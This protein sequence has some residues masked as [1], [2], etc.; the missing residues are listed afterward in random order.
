MMKQQGE[1]LAHWQ[2]STKMWDEF[3]TIEK[4]NKKEDNIY[5]GIGILIIAS[6]GLMFFRNTSFWGGLVFAIPFAIVIPWLRMKF[7]YTYLKKGSKNPEVKIFYDTLWINQKKIELRGDRK[8]I[9]SLKVI[10]AKNDLKLLEFDVQWM[11]A[12]GP[13]NDEFRILIP[14]SELEEV[15]NLIQKLS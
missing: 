7:S 8:R 3:V 4:G 6:L 1:L 13:T 9:K 2:Y 12:K 15:E 10:S 14:K 11:T 5:F